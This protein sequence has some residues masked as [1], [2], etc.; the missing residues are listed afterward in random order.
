MPKSREKSLSN[1][2]SYTFFTV[3]R[4]ICKVSSNYILQT[5][6]LLAQDFLKLHIIKSY[7]VSISYKKVQLVIIF[8]LLIRLKIYKFCLKF[9]CFELEK[10]ED[11][12]TY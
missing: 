9:E 1:E 6:R 7:C 5:L 8:L 3:Y 10:K 2:I 4:R 11:I 12:H